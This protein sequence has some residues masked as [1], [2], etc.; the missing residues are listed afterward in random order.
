MCSNALPYCWIELSNATPEE[1]VFC[2]QL[3][4]HDAFAVSLAT[5]AKCYLRMN[6]ALRDSYYFMTGKLSYLDF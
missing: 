1:Q 5:D 2:V 4:F 3:S 6:L